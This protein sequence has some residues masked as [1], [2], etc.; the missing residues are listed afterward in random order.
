MRG[1]GDLVT[2]IGQEWLLE[3]VSALSPQ[4]P[5]LPAAEGNESLR[6]EGEVSEACH[7]IYSI[8]CSLRI[9]LVCFETLGMQAGRGKALYPGP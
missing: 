6:S 5:A 4:Q 3:R 1:A 2:P 8:I 7:G 9:C